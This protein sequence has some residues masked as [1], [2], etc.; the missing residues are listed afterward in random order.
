MK[1]IPN[2]K[3]L[4][5]D[6]TELTVI[7]DDDY[8]LKNHFPH[9]KNLMIESIQDFGRTK[10]RENLK[11]YIQKF[12]KI[13]FFYKQLVHEYI[14]KGENEVAFGHASVF[15]QKFPN[16]FF[17]KLSMAQLHGVKGEHAKVR[18]ILGENLEISTAFP[19]KT[20]FHISEIV[21]FFLFRIDYFLNVD[22]LED[23][24]KTEHLLAKLIENEPAH[25]QAKQR[26]TD[27]RRE[28]LKIETTLIEV[29]DDKRRIYPYY[30]LT[31]VQI[32]QIEDFSERIYALSKPSSNLLVEMQIQADKNLE[33]PHFQNLLCEYFRHLN[34]NTEYVETVSVLYKEFPG[35][36]ISKIR[37]SE[38]LLSSE[39]LRTEKEVILDQI[40]GI[41]NEHLD[42]RKICPDRDLFLRLDEFIY[43]QYIALRVWLEKNNLAQ[44]DVCFNELQKS[45][46][47]EALIKECKKLLDNYS[48]SLLLDS[49]LN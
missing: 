11:K 32:E 7:D 38:L 13:P 10:N 16:E 18:A 43:F 14:Q 5:K 41:L 48:E 39:Q 19:G 35:F 26:I 36:L 21:N 45:Y 1:I 9:I 2:K 30:K 49:S 47:E 25:I 29:T 12:P 37:I 8:F 40:T 44:A 6:R 15:Y 23:A 31:N 4:F 17:A 24:V 28:K 46:A 27:C 3:V 34:M 22:R 33:V 42:F 20:E